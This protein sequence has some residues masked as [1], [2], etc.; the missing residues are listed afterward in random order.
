[1]YFGKLDPN[2]Q[3]IIHFFLVFITKEI[4]FFILLTYKGSYMEVYQ[5]V[6]LSLTSATG[7]TKGCLDH[8]FSAPPAYVAHCQLCINTE[9]TASIGR[10]IKYSRL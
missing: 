7:G 6:K 4:I 10:L 3:K 8:M 9:P 5:D 1:M 2:L